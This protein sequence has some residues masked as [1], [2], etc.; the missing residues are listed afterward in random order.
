MVQ[1][2]VD[3]VE[4][5]YVVEVARLRHRLAARDLLFA[6][7]EEHLEGAGK[8]GVEHRVEGPE[9]HRRVRVVAAGVHVPLPL[10]AEP[11]GGGDVV[12]VF[13]LGHRERVDVD[14]ESDYGAG[15]ALG[16]RD[17][18]GVSARKMVDDL[19]VRTR[20]AGPLF[21]LGQLLV[22]GDVHAVVGR[23][24]V[25]ADVEVREVAL[26]KLFDD[27]SGS[28]ELAP[29]GLRVAVQVAAERAVSVVVESAH[30]RR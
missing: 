20:I 18:A 27:P 14:P 30:G 26:A 16:N 3:R 15:A 21:P 2:D 19:R 10:R 1:A 9:P 22:V 7:L 8:V 4:V 23:Q 28:V 6:R 12:G 11:L 25:R 17:A 29:S 5:V 13:G 24:R